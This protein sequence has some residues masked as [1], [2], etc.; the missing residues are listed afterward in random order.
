[1]ENVAKKHRVDQN[2]PEGYNPYTRIHFCSNELVNVKYIIDDNGFYPLL[3]GKGEQP[4]IW[5][6]AKTGEDQIIPIIEKNVS[7]NQ[8]VSVENYKGERIIK[9]NVKTESGKSSML[10]IE[11][12]GDRPNVYY[13]DLRPIGYSIYGDS[14]SLNVGNS[15]ISD[16]SIQAEAAIGIGNS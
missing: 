12:G 14:E 10:E 4:V 13:L 11:Y 7:K 5:I 1:M 3:I 2:I 16:S 15:V 9:V 8:L 6:Y